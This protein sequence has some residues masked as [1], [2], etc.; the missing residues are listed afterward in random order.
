MHRPTRVGFSTTNL[1]TRGVGLG[2]PISMPTV[3]V[4]ACLPARVRCC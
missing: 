4:C 2:S 3:A 1:D